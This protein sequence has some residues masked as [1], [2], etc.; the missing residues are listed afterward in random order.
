MEQRRR[1]SFLLIAG[2]LSIISS[3]F[4]IVAAIVLIRWA[5]FYDMYV[6][7]TYVPYGVNPLTSVLVTLILAGLGC[8]AFAFGLSAGIFSIRKIQR[9]LCLFGASI[10]LVFGLLASVNFSVGGMPALGELNPDFNVH[11]VQFSICPLSFFALVSPIIFL[12]AM[13]MIFVII[14]KAEFTQSKEFSD[15]K[16]SEEK[17]NKNGSFST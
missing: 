16:T 17:G 5:Y 13:S 7:D 4:T 3:C 14:R 8:L 6:F 2:I 10:L 11:P 15:L 9:S 12:S 1:N